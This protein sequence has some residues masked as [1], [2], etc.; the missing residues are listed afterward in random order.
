MSDKRISDYETWP[1]GGVKPTLGVLH[2]LAA[3]YNSTPAQLIDYR[4]EQA[5]NSQERAAIQAARSFSS[6]SSSAQ[7]AAAAPNSAQVLAPAE[8][9]RGDVL[10]HPSPPPASSTP[11][12][13]PGEI[14]AF[15]NRVIALERLDAVFAEYQ[16]D[17]HAPGLVLISGTAGVG[18]TSLAVHWAHRVHN[19]FSKGSL[20]VDLRGYG[21]YSPAQP[22]DVLG[23]FMRALGIPVADI[24]L[25]I[26]DRVD[27]YRS[28][29]AGRKIL[30]ILDNAATVTQVRPLLPGVSGPL[31]LI[32]SRNLLSGL[33]A[34]DG[35]L[36]LPLNLLTESE[37]VDLLMATI[38]DYRPVDHADD[39]A[40]LARLCARL[41]LAL[42]IAAERA[43]ARPMMPLDELIAD[44]REESSLWDALSLEDEDEANRVRS[45]FSW[46]Y[47]ALPPDAARLFRLLGVHPGQDISVDGASAL[48]AQPARTTRRLLDHLVGTHLLERTGPDRYQFHDLLRA[49]AGDQ[50]Q[51]VERS[52]SYLALVRILTWYLHTAAAVVAATQTFFPAI[53]LKSPEENIAPLAFASATEAT[54]WYLNE[55]ENIRSAATAAASHSLDT[56][57][58]QFPAV[59]MPIHVVRN[60]FDDWF[61]LGRIGIDAARRLHNRHAEAWMLSTLGFAYSQSGQNVKAGQYLGEAIL[62]HQETGDYFGEINCVSALGWVYLRTRNLPRAI[63]YFG[64]AEGLARRHDDPRWRHVCLSNTAT[65]QLEAGNLEVAAEYAQQAL[66]VMRRMRADK[67]LEFDKLLNLARTHRERNQPGDAAQYL[68]EAILV[69]D[70]TSGSFQARALLEEGHQHYSGGRLED[71]MTVYQKASALF[72]E[73]PDRV[74]E[75]QIFDAVGRIYRETGRVEQALEFH[76]RAAVIFEKLNRTFDQ[77]TALEHVARAHDILGDHGQ[78]Q[79]C[80]VEA[81]DL[82]AGFDDPRAIALKELIQR[83]LNGVVGQQ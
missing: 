12:L 71:A 50:A 33:A 51:H 82:L 2:V 60:S 49:Y 79:T 39:V 13:L 59:L 20:Y 4:D 9:A 63:Q 10:L 8:I 30:I 27:Q 24:A 69:A 46:S 52:E 70:E 22:M 31:V 29:V 5:F 75:A 73:L 35:A 78:S 34:R 53:P 43:A 14:Q 61:A 18:K 62:G 83:A 47:R 28:L 16:R 32:T 3:V 55:A 11:H 64:Q 72:R 37:S 66:V 74:G 48:C 26:D 15:V 19:Q 68:A 38:R 25:D 7:P 23:R 17:P 36:R 41:P 45:V 42:R 58:W 81:L 21:P 44:L 76:G 40:Q 1:V 77:A 57:A 6:G 80:W 67:R 56:I 54:S 65:A